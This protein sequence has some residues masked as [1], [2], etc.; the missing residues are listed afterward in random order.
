MKTKFFIGIIGLISVSVL[1]ATTC[2]AQDC[3][4]TQKGSGNLIIVSC[5]DG[6]KTVDVGGR[7]DLYRVGDRINISGNQPVTAPGAAQSPGK[8]VNQQTQL[9]TETQNPGRR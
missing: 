3:V 7:V 6:S 4:V 9:P 8:S 2:F 5:P 1:L